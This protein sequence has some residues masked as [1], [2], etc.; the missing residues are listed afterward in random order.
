MLDVFEVFDQMQAPVQRSVLGAA[1]LLVAAGAPIAIWFFAT[2]SP[3]ARLIAAR[4]LTWTVI[5]FV[6]ALSVFLD[7]TDGIIER[8]VNGGRYVGFWAPIALWGC[9]ET[10]RLMLIK[11]RKLAR[12]LLGL[13]WIAALLVGGLHLSEL[14]GN[15]LVLLFVVALFD[16][17]GWVGGKTLAR[18]RPFDYKIFKTTSPN[19]TLGGL[20]VSL[21]LG[22][23][24]WW[25]AFTGFGFF[26]E[27]KPASILGFFTLAA[28][29]VLGD[30][31]A[32]KL[33]RL[34]KVKD[35]GAIIVGF[36]GVLDRFDSII[37]VGVGAL[38]FNYI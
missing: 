31:L 14:V 30:Y 3:A 24:A 33:K 35:A 16:I 34:A 13:V 38:L 23:F 37:W 9:F 7:P 18:L 27:T 26:A 17:G 10:V 11:P 29:A 25:W 4:L 19:K 28:F 2:R 6:S 22:A 32:S 12:T 8:G 36:G 5:F 1:T 15:S 21:A 20:V